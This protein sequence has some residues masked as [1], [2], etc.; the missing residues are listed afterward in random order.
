M[1]DTAEEQPVKSLSDELAEALRESEERDSQE[2]QE[3]EEDEAETD[4]SEEESADED[5]S[6]DDDESDQDTDDSED[7]TEE[8]SDDEPIKAPEHWSAADRERFES[9]PD[10]AKDFVLERH[11]AMEGDYTRKT[12]ELASIRK[13]GEALEEVIGPY[14]QEFQLSGLDDVAAIRQL[15]TVHDALKRDPNQAIQWL[16]QTYGAD[17][18]S[19]D[20]Q[21]IDPTVA[22]LKRQIQQM[23]QEQQHQALT[24]QQRQQQEIESQ[25]KAFEEEKDADGSLKHPSF[26]DVQDDMAVLIQAGRAT[27]MEDAYQKAIR[28]RPDMFETIQK[29]QTEQAK[30]KE[31]AEKAKLAKRAKK[32][33]SGVKSSGAGVKKD[34]PASLHDE[35]ASLVNQQLNQ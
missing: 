13:R 25:I 18:T 16:A 30:Q 22:E 8:E 27:D 29:K 1:T 2:E 23:R 26:M 12:Q 14:R 4:D 15:F 6:E 10:E 11:K 21:N 7:D 28:M 31:K 35:I 33:A 32:A 9:L 19:T 17:L 3:T 20:D 5:D 34:A 24:A